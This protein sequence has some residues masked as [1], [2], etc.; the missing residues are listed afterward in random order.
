MSLHDRASSSNCLQYN[1]VNIHSGIWLE[2]GDS[3]GIHKSS[4]DHGITSFIGKYGRSWDQCHEK[5]LSRSCDCIK[6]YIW[7]EWVRIDR[8]Y[9]WWQSS[10]IVELNRSYPG[11]VSNR[12]TRQNI[13]HRS[14]FIRKNKFIRLKSHL[15]AIWILRWIRRDWLK[16]LNWQPTS[17][18]CKWLIRS[19]R[20]RWRY[21]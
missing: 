7:T 18:E 3:P 1:L 8:A 16:Q 10:R 14:H 21:R 13:S 4:G 9:C 17:H 6:C 5:W 19:R 12:S 15:L 2:R 11:P 20:A